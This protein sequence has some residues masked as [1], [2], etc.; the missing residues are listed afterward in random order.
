MEKTYILKQYNKEYHVFI[1]FLQTLRCN[2]LS[3]ERFVSSC[4]ND[5]S[6]NYILNINNYY[7][8]C[9][10]MNIPTAEAGADELSFKSITDKELID[11]TIIKENETL[12]ICHPN[13]IFTGPELINDEIDYILNVNWLKINPDKMIGTNNYKKF[14]SPSEDIIKEIKEMLSINLKE[15]SDFLY[16]SYISI[17]S[18]IKTQKEFLYYVKALIKHNFLGL[19]CVLNPDPKPLKLTKK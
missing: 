6:I 3:F 13:N 11:L 8:F 7:E 14:Q 12:F 18:E 5:E 1:E 19:E 2:I 16:E 4:A 17:V 15:K 9:K 10:E